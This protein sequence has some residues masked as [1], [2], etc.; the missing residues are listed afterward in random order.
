MCKLFYVVVMVS[1][2]LQGAVQ[3]E[4]IS[5]IINRPQQKTAEFAILAVRASDGKRLYSRNAEKPMIPASNMKLVS[6][7]AA[8]HYLGPDY[9]YQTRLAMLGKNVVVIGGGDPMLGDEQIDQRYG[10]KPGWIF[11]QILQLLQE[12]GI[13]T[14]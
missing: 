9:H 4:T 8:L 10:R 2:I 13:T 7:S 14:N 1:L 6:S 5:Q 12:R 11:E 3:A